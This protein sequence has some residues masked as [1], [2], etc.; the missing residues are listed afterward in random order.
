M[1]QPNSV[2]VPVMNRAPKQV[3]AR[4]RKGQIAGLYPPSASI[5]PR[6]DV[7]RLR[8]VSSDPKSP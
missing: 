7:S 4:R 1:S 2:Y 3:R 8:T 5:Y 6:D